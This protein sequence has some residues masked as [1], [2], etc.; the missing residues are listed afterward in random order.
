MNADEIRMKCAH[1]LGW[2]NV[3]PPRGHWTDWLG[4]NPSENMDQLVPDFPRSLD[5]CSQMM[6]SLTDGERADFVAALSRIVGFGKGWNHDGWNIANA[7]AEQICR[8]YLA[9]KGIL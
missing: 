3:N 4:T 5:A 8:A 7:T 1:V 9:A 2:T 6:A